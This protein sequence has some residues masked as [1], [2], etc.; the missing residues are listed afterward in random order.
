MTA[1]PVAGIR[2]HAT[3]RRAAHR[4]VASGCRLRRCPNGAAIDPDDALGARHPARSTMKAIQLSRFGGPEVLEYVSAPEPAVGASELLVRTEAI[5]VNYI[6]IYYREGIYKAPLPFI[7]GDEACGVIEAVGSEV[8]GFAAGDRVAWTSPH[9]S[10]AQ[11]VAVPAE[12]AVPVPRELDA[13]KA[14]SC[15]AQGMTAH[16]LSHSTY[17]IQPE[18]TV[19]IHAGAGGVGLLLTQMAV[20]RGARVITTVSRDV[21][22]AASLKAGAAHVVRYGPEVAEQVR[23]LTNGRGVAATYDGVGASTFRASLAATAI[24]GT[25][26]LFGAASGPVPP[27]DPQDLNAAGSLYLTRPTIGDYVRDRKELLWRAND[28]LQGV[29]NGSLDVAIGGAYELSEARQAHADLQS[30]STTGALV[31]IP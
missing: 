18:D 24:R 19:L 12:A 27:F 31:L 13:A 30:R 17:A 1:L 5:G 23:E 28:V 9:G 20:A 6:D 4:P 2:I 11:L 16:Y 8:S 26:A 15:L 7:P 3:L 10:Y 14:A 22:A 29:Y 25:V 21:K